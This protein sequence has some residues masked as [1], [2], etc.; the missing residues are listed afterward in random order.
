MQTN[1]SESSQRIWIQFLFHIEENLCDRKIENCNLTGQ[2]NVILTIEQ[3]NRLLWSDEIPFLLR[4]VGRTRVWRQ[5]NERY[6]DFCVKGTVVLEIY[7]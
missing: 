1:H 3:Y 5:P 2:I 6:K 7:I 4:Y